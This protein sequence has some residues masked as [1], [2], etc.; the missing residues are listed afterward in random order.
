ML[1]SLKSKSMK[2]MQNQL[3]VI[4]IVLVAQVLNAQ[5]NPPEWQDL[6][7]FEVNTLKPRATFYVFD[8]ENEALENDYYNSK[9]LL[10]LK[11]KLKTS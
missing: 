8:T 5:Q 6:R 2:R 9:N 10:L 4:L 11:D 1:L 7:I 3:S